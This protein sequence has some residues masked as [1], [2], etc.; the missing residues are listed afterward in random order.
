M[1]K[2]IR[3]GGTKPTIG[4]LCGLAMG[5]LQF[6]EI[7]GLSSESKISWFNFLVDLK[8]QSAI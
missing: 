1:D 6:P 5:N 8:V 4:P 7:L 2:I 3:C